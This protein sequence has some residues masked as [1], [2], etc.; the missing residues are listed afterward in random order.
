MTV[1]ATVTSLV[2]GMYLF[3]DAP[4]NSLKLNILTHDS[5]VNEETKTFIVFPCPMH[6]T[7]LAVFC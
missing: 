3:L 6:R 1:T 5:S 4:N 2:V 7:N